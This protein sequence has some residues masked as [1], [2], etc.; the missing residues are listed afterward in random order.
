MHSLVVSTRKGYLK[1][2]EET[3]TINIEKGKCLQNTYLVCLHRELMN[4]GETLVENVEHGYA[5]YVLVQRVLIT[6]VTGK[7]VAD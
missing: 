6:T 7:L 2:L 3:T 1:V 5:N 4:V